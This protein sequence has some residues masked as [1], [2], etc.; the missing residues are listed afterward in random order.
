MSFVAS[1]VLSDLKPYY[2]ISF[3]SFY[4]QKPGQVIIFTT[5]YITMKYII[6]T[7]F[8]F[9]LLN[10]KPVNAIN[11]QFLPLSS[12][13]YMFWLTAKVMGPF[14]RSGLVCDSSRL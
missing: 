13:F 7:P 2:K 5:F 8:L 12:E 11:I 14:P 3:M 4:S 9:P 1:H 6:M 10:D